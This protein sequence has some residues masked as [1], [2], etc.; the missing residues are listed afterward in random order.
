MTN[1]TVKLPLFKQ[2]MAKILMAKIPVIIS[3]PSDFT[4]ITRNGSH[5]R[6]PTASTGSPDIH[7]RFTENMGPYWEPTIDLRAGHREAA[8]ELLM[9]EVRVGQL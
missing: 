9:E 1:C 3:H 2:L 6:E 7:K 5:P 4:T 8:Q